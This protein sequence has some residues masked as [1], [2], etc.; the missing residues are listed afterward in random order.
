MLSFVVNCRYYSCRQCFLD[1]DLNLLLSISKLCGPSARSRADCADACRLACHTEHI[2]S[3]FDDHCPA[4]GPG[5]FVSADGFD[6]ETIGTR[7]NPFASGWH[8]ACQWPLQVLTAHQWGSPMADAV[9]T[10]L[11]D[12]V[13]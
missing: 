10:P 9:S 2:L 11:E 3:L 7:L 5:G 6:C 13:W 1:L 8:R 12:K 4:S